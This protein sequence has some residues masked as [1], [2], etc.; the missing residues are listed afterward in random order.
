MFEN[1]KVIIWDF[2]GVIMDSMPIR[3]LGF[4]KVLASYPREQVEELLAFHEENGGLSRYVKFRYFFEQIRKQEI[5]EDEVI[6]L[7]KSF[8]R[9]MLSLLIDEKLLINDSVEFIRKNA[10]KYEMHIASG[11]DGVELNEICK[12][13]NL[14]LFFKSINGSPTPK[15][16]IVKQLLSKN[17]YN[18][19]DV[20]LIGDSKNDYDAT[21]DNNIDFAGYNNESMLNLTNK[22]IYSFGSL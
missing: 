9:I 12:G 8:N 20:V 16:E 18:I 15:T 19:S 22:Y 11:S 21:V 6:E 2:D 17:N 7:A 3:G 10:D 4:E 1:Y 5:S 14:S 13:L